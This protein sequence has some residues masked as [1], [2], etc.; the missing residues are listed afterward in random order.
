LY[1]STLY[2]DVKEPAPGQS[3]GREVCALK[4]LSADELKTVDFASSDPARAGLWAAGLGI[5][6]VCGEI[7][8]GWWA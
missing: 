6:P 4:F 7:G 1:F 8:V 5:D 3:P 2:A